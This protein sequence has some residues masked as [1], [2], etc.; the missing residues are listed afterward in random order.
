M[1]ILGADNEKIKGT[2]G[3]Q[4]RS[5]SQNSLENH[6]NENDPLALRLPGLLLGPDQLTAD[7]AHAPLDSTALSKIG[8][9]KWSSR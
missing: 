4:V 9:K 1:L 7:P 3:W 8:Q 5:R 6:W 2:K